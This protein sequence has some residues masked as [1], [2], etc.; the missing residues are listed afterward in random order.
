MGPYRINIKRDLFFP[1]HFSRLTKQ[2]ETYILY[3][4]TFPFVSWQLCLP[5]V[6]KWMWEYHS[7]T[8]KVDEKWVSNTRFSIFYAPLRLNLP[9]AHRHIWCLRKISYL[10]KRTAVKSAKKAVISQGKPRMK[11]HCTSFILIDSSLCYVL[12]SL[13]NVTSVSAADIIPL[14]VLS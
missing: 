14:V 13:E 11:H 7:V 4:T 2:Q 8:K 6:T 9:L 5:N 1:V 10:E 12:R 3:A